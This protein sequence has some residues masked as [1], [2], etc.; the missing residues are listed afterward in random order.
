MLITVLSVDQTISKWEI[1]IFLVF[2][3]SIFFFFLIIES[4]CVSSPVVNKTAEL[5]EVA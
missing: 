5:R 4:S 2:P 1:T 3:F